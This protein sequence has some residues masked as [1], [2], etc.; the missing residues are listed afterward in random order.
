MDKNKSGKQETVGGALATA[1]AIGFTMISTLIVGVWLGRWADRA[2]DV[3]P[4][5]TVS[6]IILGMLAGLW[7]MYKKITKGT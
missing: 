6:G 5:G 4:W 1:S 7:S 3:T 2:W